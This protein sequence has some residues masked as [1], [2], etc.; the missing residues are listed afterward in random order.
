VRTQPIEARH[1]R[2]LEATG[3]LECALRTS[4]RL[5]DERSFVDLVLLACEFSDDALEIEGLVDGLVAVSSSR[6]VP[7]SDDPMLGCRPGSESAERPPRTW[8][9]AKTM[10]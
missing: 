6:L 4:A 10:P 8:A 9:D 1:E 7:A 2:P 5:G 3:P